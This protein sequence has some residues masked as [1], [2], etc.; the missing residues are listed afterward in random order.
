MEEREKRRRKIPNL[1]VSLMPCIITVDFSALV[2]LMILIQNIIILKYFGTPT[3]VKL[4]HSSF[5]HFPS[6]LQHPKYTHKLH[7]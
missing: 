6:F 7:S 5:P 3:S 4:L 1:L 2:S